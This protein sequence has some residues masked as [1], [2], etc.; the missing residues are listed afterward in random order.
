MH[1]ALMG[2]QWGDEGKGKLIDY[3]A[4]NFDVVCRYQGGANAGHTVLYKG[5]N[6]YLHLV[7]SGIFHPNKI[8]IIGNG[9]V[10]DIKK[11]QEELVQLKEKGIDFDNRFFI[12]KRCHIIQPEHFT[13]EER[14]QKDIGTTGRGIGPAYADKISRSGVRMGDIFSIKYIKKRGVNTD[15]IKSLKTFKENF[16]QFITDTVDLLH[17]LTRKE[18]KILFEGAQGVMLD[19]DFGT[20]PYVTSSNPS[21]GGILTG[22]GISPFSISKIIGVAKTYTTRVGNGPLPTQM[23]NNTQE[24]I[25]DVGG[26]Y[27][28]T[29][30]R[31]RRC[32]WL[33]LVA[34]KYAV[35]ISGATEI[36]LTKI[37]VLDGLSQIKIGTEYEI[38]GHITNK[39]P[40]EVWNLERAKPIYTIF[41]GWDNTREIKEYKRLPEEAKEYIHYIEEYVGVKVSMISI[42]KKRGDLII[43]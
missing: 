8:C 43:V 19:I 3:L 13:R 1:T 37:D 12:S 31:P 36:A 26:E 40:A 9:T 29:T 34:L 22:T 30:G 39:F 2:L 25:R 11:L 24:M 14:M 5:E 38:D 16:G 10:I 17:S 27:G 35:Q 18:K 32:G 6:I 28:A 41:S 21:T 42:G 20:Y 7:P 15:F 4:T 23:D 33:D